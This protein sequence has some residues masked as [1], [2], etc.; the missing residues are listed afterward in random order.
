M[1][2]SLFSSIIQ[3]SL[4]YLQLHFQLVADLYLPHLLQCAHFR[5]NWL[6]GRIHG[7][8]TAPC[9]A[10]APD[11]PQLLPQPLG[12]RLVLLQFALQLA[13]NFLLSSNSCC[14]CVTWR[15]CIAVMLAICC[16]CALPY[17]TIASSFSLSS[18]ALSCSSSAAGALALRPPES[19]S[20]PGPSLCLSPGL[21]TPIMCTE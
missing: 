4:Q 3:L 9:L 8:S 13:T 12:L 17:I 15:S 11:L 19:L 7:P 20:L 6:S 5:D 14:S 16:E 21:L 18:R 2:G 1:L 10:P